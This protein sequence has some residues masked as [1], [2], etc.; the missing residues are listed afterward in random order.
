MNQF[1]VTLLRSFK[2]YLIL[3][4]LVIVC[5]MLMS[6]SEHESTQKLRSLALSTFSQISGI[7]GYVNFVSDIKS[8]NEKLRRRNAELMLENNQLREFGLENRELRDMLAFEDTSSY[9]L[10]AAEVISKSF[11]ADQI[12]FTI[13]RGAA[14]SVKPG[15]P[16]ISQ[17]GLVGIVYTTADN[18]SIVRT[19]KNVNLKLIVKLINSGTPGILKW[20]GTELIMQGIPKTLQ[21]QKGERIV[22]SEVSSLIGINIPVGEVSR[23]LNPE[24][25]LFNDLLLTPLADLN[26]TDNIFVMRM[27]QSKKVDNYELNYLNTK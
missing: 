8:E 6:I 5:F 14:D 26:S 25:G 27:I 15:M 9:E 22:T 11:L 18:Y 16:V 7:F 3:I 19:Y 21:I 4:V 10:I 17:S 2:A 23:I 20:N 12:N 24:S 1:F 13:N